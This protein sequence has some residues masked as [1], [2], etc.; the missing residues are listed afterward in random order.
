MPVYHDVHHRGVFPFS[1]GV[2]VP[3]APAT[4]DQR[5]YLVYIV[6][7]LPMCAIKQSTSTPLKYTQIE[8]THT[9]TYSPSVSLSGSKTPAK[10]SS[11]NNTKGTR[12]V[13]LYQ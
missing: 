7:I 2:G 11:S 1:T 4:L 8:Y 3:R 6:Y 10:N 9:T 12:Y 5:V 13:H